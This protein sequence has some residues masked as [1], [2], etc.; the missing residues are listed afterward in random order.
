MRQ[1][2]CLTYHDYK[3]SKILLQ[4]INSMANKLPVAQLVKKSIASYGIRYYVL[5]A[6]DAP[7]HTFSI[8]C[9]TVL[10][11]API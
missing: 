6:A 4:Y 8:H 9:N 1:V 5:N 11:P 10:F 7:H 2:I 3:S